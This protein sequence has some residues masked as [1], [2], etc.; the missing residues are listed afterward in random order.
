MS[1][2]DMKQFL[3]KFYCIILI[4]LSYKFYHAAK[5]VSKVRIGV[6]CEREITYVN[7]M[8]QNFQVYQL[9]TLVSVTALLYFVVVEG[10]VVGGKLIC[11]IHHFILSV[12]TF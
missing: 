8:S 6:K 2:Y 3:Q 10:I 9:L 1:P 11:P 4:I 5:K 7:I 12:S